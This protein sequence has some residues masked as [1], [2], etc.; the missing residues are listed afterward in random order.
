MVAALEIHTHADMVD[1]VVYICS[2]HTYIRLLCKNAPALRFSMDIS[3]CSVVP[4]KSAVQFASARVSINSRVWE[5]KRGLLSRPRSLVESVFAQKRGDSSSYKLVRSIY[6]RVTDIMQ[7]TGGELQSST[8]QFFCVMS[9]RIV[10]A[11]SCPMP[12][13]SRPS[14]CP[15]LNG[16]RPRALGSGLNLP[17]SAF[18]SLPPRRLRQEERST[19]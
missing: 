10:L 3:P 15:V 19:C 14:P 9:G 4:T 8:G 7:F 16:E 18:W 1:V 5:Q 2:H 13:Y 17:R 12:F 11:P 6:E